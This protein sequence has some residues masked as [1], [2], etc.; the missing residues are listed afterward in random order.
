MSDDSF[1]REVDQ[2]LRQDKA[3]ALWDRYGTAIIAAA[4]AIV[5]AT[6][7][8][9]GWDYWSQSRAD[10][11]GDAYLQAL[12]LARDGKAD[13]A[14]AALAA[15]EADGYGAYPV[16]ARMRGATLMAEQGDYAGAVS[17]FDSVA[18]DSAIPMALREMARL[19]AGLLLVDHGA[20]ADVAQR[21]ETLT[22]ETNPLRHS[23]REALALAAWKEGR[24]ADAATLFDQIV[25]DDA[26]PQGARQR[27]TM[28][29]ELIRGSG[30]SS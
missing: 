7:A 26:A 19:R 11:S 21:V 24:A 29:S 22:A 28:M 8:F 18:A 20:Y 17:A 25:N 4:V 13:E 16:L 14:K 10:A 9:V 6:A 1:F 3:K 27:A 2:E 5:L 23:A 30:A 15:L 12:E